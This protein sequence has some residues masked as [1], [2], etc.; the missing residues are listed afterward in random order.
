LRGAW[1][2]D[3]KL[4]DPSFA[5]TLQKL[6]GCEAMDDSLFDWNAANIAHIDF[7][8]S[9][10]REERWTYIGQ[11]ARSRVLQVVI[12]MRCGKVRIVTAFEPT[13]QDKM[14]YLETLYLETKAGQ[15]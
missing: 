5:R 8:S 7:D 3:T 10:G 14:L 4:Y 1:I 12:T 9:E 6:E 13:R 11:T 15:Q 2:G